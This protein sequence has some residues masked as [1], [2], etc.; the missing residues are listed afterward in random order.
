MEKWKSRT[1]R[2]IPL[3]P[4]AIDLDF[5]SV[6]HFPS[7]VPGSETEGDRDAHWLAMQGVDAESMCVELTTRRT[8]RWQ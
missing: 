7:G 6:A 1:D 4:Q 2:E 3:F 5:G 8:L